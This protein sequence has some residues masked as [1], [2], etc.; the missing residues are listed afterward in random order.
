MP[1]PVQLNT[2][3]LEAL[4]ARLKQLEQENQVLRRLQQS[5]Q[6]LQQE[7]Q[8]LQITL[9]TATEHGDAI[10]DELQRINQQLRQEITERQ[11]AETTL[12]VMLEFLRRQHADLRIMLDILTEH[13]DVVDEQWN[14]KVD[15][16]SY[17]AT[18]DPLTQLAN[19]RK[20]DDY[21]KDHWRQAI[22]THRPLNI[23][24]C[25]IDFF[26]QYNDT[27]GHPQ[28]DSCLQQIAACLSQSIAPTEGLVARYGG[29]EFAVVL[30]GMEVSQAR[31]RAE[32]IVNAVN[33]LEI[34]HLSSPVTH[35]VT[36]SI[37]LATTVPAP[38]TYPQM[39]VDRAD[40]QLYLAKSQGRNRIMIDTQPLA[41]L[42]AASSIV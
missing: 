10:E 1:E 33:A 26:K 13:G 39:L 32:A 19:R 20:F 6:T 29:E 14:A 4:Y 7:N 38:D 21:L 34:P 9:L 15:Q 23:L 17:L 25:D 12:Y 16:M 18:V 37:G 3:E 28:G 41:A 35:H 8:D 24:L 36:L 27:Y 11:R 2:S 5:Y 42:Q 31:G 22:D 30:P 40:R